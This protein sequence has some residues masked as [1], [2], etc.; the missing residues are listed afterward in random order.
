MMMMTM[1]IPKRL[2][3]GLQ[4]VTTGTRS[5]SSFFLQGQ[6][7]LSMY[8]VLSNAVLWMT[9]KLIFTPIYFMY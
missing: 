5:L 7:F 8:A 6:T 3:L 1:S 4:E 2:V 9:F